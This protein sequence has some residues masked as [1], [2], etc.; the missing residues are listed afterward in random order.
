MLNS[1]LRVRSSPKPVLC[2][3]QTFTTSHLFQDIIRAGCGALVESDYND[4]VEPLGSGQPR[5]NARKHRHCI[6]DHW[7][8]KSRAAVEGN[9]K[10][11]SSEDIDIRQILIIRIKR[12]QEIVIMNTWGYIV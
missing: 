11:G 9:H 12:P 10:N 8:P 1:T 3:F 5:F 2:C 6:G 7:V 4:Q